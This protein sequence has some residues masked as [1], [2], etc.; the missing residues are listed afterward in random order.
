MKGVTTMAKNIKEL[1]AEKKYDDAADILYLA[2]LNLFNNFSSEIGLTKE[3][4]MKVTPAFVEKLETP[5]R[6]PKEP[7]PEP[8]DDV[9]ITDPF[10]TLTIEF[11][12]PEDDEDF[13]APAKVEKKYAIGAKYSYAVPTVDGYVPDK[14]LVTGKMVKDGVKV[15]VTYEKEVEPEKVN[16]TIQYVGPE[17]DT[18][19]VAPATYTQELESG[20]EYFVPSPAVEGYTPDKESV[21]GAA[22][23]VDIEE[24]VTYTKNAAKKAT[25]TVNYVGPEGDEDFPAQTAHTEELSVGDIYS[26]ESPEVTGYIPD[27]AVV[28]GIVESE[29]DITE[30]VTY[31]KSEQEFEGENEEPIVEG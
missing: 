23:D 28:E 6:E 3:E 26:V 30:T 9:I 31:I 2:F 15:T 19:F 20:E 21:S 1:I 5:E 14:E 25:L 4:F 12:G 13:V 10:G 16:L 11:K 8:G 17:G 24:T 29:E 7:T 18:E 22:E 27:K